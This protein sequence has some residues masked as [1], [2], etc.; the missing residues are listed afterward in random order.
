[1]TKAEKIQDL[2]E[3]IEVLTA[4]EPCQYWPQWEKEKDLARLQSELASLT[5]K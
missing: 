1:M 3:E 4:Q 2:R 5:A